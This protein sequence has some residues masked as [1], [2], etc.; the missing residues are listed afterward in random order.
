MISRGS[1]SSFFHVFL[2][3]YWTNTASEFL[4]RWLNFG[5]CS[6]FFC[7]NEEGEEHLRQRRQQLPF[8]LATGEGV[9][10]DTWMDAFSM[11]GPPGSHAP[12]ATEPTAEEAL[13]PASLL[14]S[15]RR[16]GQSIY[17]NPQMPNT[18]L[19]IF[20]QIEDVDLE[21]PQSSLEQAFLDSHALLSVP[22]QTQPPQQSSGTGDLT[23]EAMI[24]SL[25]QILGDI[26][27]GGLEGVQIEETEL[28]EWGSTLKRM[29]QERTDTSEEL[30][31]ILANDVFSYVEE[32]LRRD[33][34]GFVQASNEAWANTSE[35]NPLIQEDHH[36]SVFSNNEQPTTDLRS[37]IREQTAFGDVLCGVGCSTGERD[38]FG[39][40]S[41]RAAH[42][43]PSTQCH[44]THPGLWPSTSSAQ[45]CGDQMISSQSCHAD[46]SQPG[47]IPQSGLPAVQ[48]TNNSYSSCKSGSALTDQSEQN[49]LHHTDKVP[50]LRSP[51]VWQRPQ[52]PHTVTHGLHTPGSLNSTVPFYHPQKQS[53]TGSCMYE[54]SKGHVPDSATVP[55]RQNGPLLG[56]TCSRGSSHAA[57]TAPNAPFTLSHPDMAVLNQGTMQPSGCHMVASTDVGNFSLVH[58]NGDNTGLGSAQTGYPPENGSFQSSF[59]CWNGEAQVKKV[60]IKTNLHSLSSLLKINVL[61]IKNKHEHCKVDHSHD[62]FWSET[63]LHYV[64]KY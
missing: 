28:R 13:D 56:P 36:D 46:H 15:L 43:Q 18:Q 24:E 61:L 57:W 35:S 47:T 17:T 30:N 54:E 6:L 38:T 48:N 52:L 11:P 1:N 27:D 33:T 64:R 42:T 44:N 23:A 49:T 40:L 2:L 62:A 45:H 21:Q 16:Q 22:G 53:S 51:S 58:L 19:P 32:A 14:G 7:R 26:G 29:N 55:D 34:C 60:P 37:A 8:T 39:V 10:Y 5:C 12:D 20:P 25:E 63:S 50:S 9:L 59:Y 41:H 31:H 4:L 3:E